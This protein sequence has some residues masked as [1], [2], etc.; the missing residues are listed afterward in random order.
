MQT[1]GGQDE[2]RSP[3]ALEG[4]SSFSTEGGRGAVSGVGDL[5]WFGD[6]LTHNFSVGRDKKG[7]EQGSGGKRSGFK[8]HLLL[9]PAV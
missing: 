5:D 2:K 1:A 9:V 4:G 7:Q 3:Q 6:S 8:S